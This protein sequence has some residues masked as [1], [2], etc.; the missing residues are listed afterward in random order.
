LSLFDQLQKY[1]SLIS[2]DQTTIQCNGTML[3]VVASLLGGWVL[4]TKAHIMGF[5]GGP[6]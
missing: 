2:L 6:L 5:V 1:V 3:S 4:G